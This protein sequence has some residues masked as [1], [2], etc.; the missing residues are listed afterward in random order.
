MIY[1]AR[2]TENIDLWCTVYCITGFQ[3]HLGDHY[4]GS[5]RRC[6]RQATDKLDIIL[7]PCVRLSNVYIFFK[8]R[9]RSLLPMHAETVIIVRYSERTVYTYLT[10]VR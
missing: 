6:R 1:L 9:N 4:A 7:F 8:I 3:R 2:S 5:H 10:V